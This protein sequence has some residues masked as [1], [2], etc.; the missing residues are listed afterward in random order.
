MNTRFCVCALLSVVLTDHVVH[1]TACED[2]H[3]AEIATCSNYLDTCLAGQQFWRRS[4]RSGDLCDCSDSQSSSSE[5]PYARRSPSGACTCASNCTC[6]FA[7]VACYTGVCADFRRALEVASMAWDPAQCKDDVPQCYYQTFGDPHMGL[8]PPSR[9]YTSRTCGN[10]LFSDLY[11]SR[12]VL[13]AARARVDRQSRVSWVSSLT[14]VLAGRTFVIDARN[15]TIDVG[16]APAG[17]LFAAGRR[18][19]DGM[20]GAGELAYISVVSWTG[21]F[22]TVYLQDSDPL[23]PPYLDL[24]LYGLC[25]GNSTL[26]SNSCPPDATRRGTA[27]ERGPADAMA[28]DEVAQAA[29]A[30]L[31]GAFLEACVTD[32]RATGS[33]ESAVS[34]RLMSDNAQRAAD[35]YAAWGAV[36]TA[37]PAAAG[38]SGT[39]IGLAAAGAAA[40]AIALSAGA[41]AAVV[42][43][44]R[45]RASGGETGEDAE[46]QSSAA[47]QRER[48]ERRGVDVLGGGPCKHSS[49]TGRGAPVEV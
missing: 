24:E 33:P 14:L 21:E 25:G 16:A 34:S 4:D 27:A 13:L 42:A 32:V 7:F 2:Q 8:L 44:R 46:P 38:L 31:S 35:L 6:V 19:V 39:A 28:A 17:Y 11:A 1:S 29:C 48:T 12:T 22:L 40:G 43:A 41:A 5:V 47:C 26:Q 3:A 36:G 37:A 23:L 9:V 45:R 20:D 18:R 15:F 10:G 30:G 49:I